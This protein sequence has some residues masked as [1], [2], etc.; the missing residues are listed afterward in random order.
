MNSIEWRGAKGGGGG[1]GA[2]VVAAAA[3]EEDDSGDK[4]TETTDGSA[5][6]EGDGGGRG[7][8]QVGKGLVNIFFPV[9]ILSLP[10]LKDWHFQLFR[11]GTGCTSSD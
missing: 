2:H 5:D 6:R 8:Y 10:I 7:R 9:E 4:E 11:A 3:A 1:G